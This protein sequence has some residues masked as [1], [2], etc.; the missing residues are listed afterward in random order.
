MKTK[1]ALPLIAFS[2]LLLV[3][4]GTQQA[5][6]GVFAGDFTLTE[7]LDPENSRIEYELVNDST[8]G[9]QDEF[10]ELSVF[11]FAIEVDESFFN[12]GGP[13]GDGVHIVGRP[14]WDGGD[15]LGGLITGEEWEGVLCAGDQSDGILL[16]S[17]PR[18]G[19]NGLFT[20]NVGCFDQLFS[21]QHR[22]ALFFDLDARDGDFGGL[23]TYNP[24]VPGTSSSQGDFIIS[25]AVP[26]SR[27]VII[28]NNPDQPLCGN[29][30][31]IAVN[32]D[33]DEP[34][35]VAGEL[36]PLDSTTLLI[37]GLSSMSV[38]MI[39]AVAGLAGAGVYLVKFRANRD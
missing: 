5:F 21:G 36:L 17:D 2:V 20:E 4:A 34:P 15:A 16:T 38:F 14:G 3:P 7:T 12:G 39:P 18:F 35:Q 10:D 33:D 19:S 11:A 37:G 29:F 9:D 1:R 26:I 24:I 6:A 32:V 22:V 30:E 13:L 8:F 28:C 23:G 25:S 31:A 27:V